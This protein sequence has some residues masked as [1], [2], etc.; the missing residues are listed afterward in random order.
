MAQLARPAS[1]HWV[2]GSTDEYEQICDELVTASTFIRLNERLFPGCFYART[3]AG[4]VA[5]LDFYS[6]AAP[7]NRII[8]HPVHSIRKSSAVCIVN[9]EQSLPG[10][11]VIENSAGVL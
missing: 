9:A 5:S 2:D 3:D 1:I 4:D 11:S 8:H 7:A 6:F 10:G